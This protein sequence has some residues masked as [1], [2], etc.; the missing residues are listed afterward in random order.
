MSAFEPLL[1]RV[2]SP[3]WQRPG[4]SLSGAGASGKSGWT[5]LVN[6][7]KSAMSIEVFKTGKGLE[8]TVRFRSMRPLSSRLLPDLNARI[9]SSAAPF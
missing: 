4:E 6:A 9:E 8:A 3:I 2:R 7:T 1:V 5:L